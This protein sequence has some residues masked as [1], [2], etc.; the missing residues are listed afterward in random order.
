M[1]MRGLGETHNADGKPDVDARLKTQ[2]SLTRKIKTKSLERNKPTEQSAAK[3]GDALRYTM[4]A[5]TADYGPHTQAVFDRLMAEGYTVHEAD[6]SWVEGNTYKGINASIVAP[7]GTTFEL[8]FHTPESFVLKDGDLHEHYETMR[9]PAKPYDERLAAYKACVALSAKLPDPPGVETVGDLKRYGAPEPPKAENA[10]KPKVLDVASTDFG[11]SHHPADATNPS[12]V[13]GKQWGGWD[14]LPTTDLNLS[15]TPLN[16]TEEMLASSSIN[17]VVKGGEELRA[18]Y[19]PHIVIDGHHRVAMYGGLHRDT[20]PAKIYDERTMG[21][22]GRLTNVPPEVSDALAAIKINGRPDGEGTLE[23]PIAVG[24][25]LDLAVKLLGEGKHIRLNQPEQVA[26]LVGRLAA[27]ATRLRD[28]G[29]DEP[30]FDLCHVSVPGTNLFCSES[31][32]IDRSDMPQFSGQAVPG[33]PAAEIANAKGKADVSAAFRAELKARGISVVAR[34]MPASHLRATQRELNGA[35]IGGMMSALAA[36]DLPP[37]A[38]FVTREGYV[39]DGHH[40]WAANV[41]VDVQDNRLG[42]SE[43]PVEVVDMDVGAAIDFANEFTKRMGIKAKAVNEGFPA[44][45]AA[46]TA[47]AGVPAPALTPT[48]D[49]VVS[50]IATL[51]PDRVAALVGAGGVEAATPEQLRALID[52]AAKAEAKV[53][54]APDAVAAALASLR[55]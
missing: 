46:P 1:K 4:T 54:I 10:K 34:T 20:M 31:K 49:A 33:S 8:Q 23:D 32:G 35:K 48:G 55:R 26:T 41:A 45:A 29:Q 40:R 37:G 47:T 50:A 19:D 13:V 9:D 51:G 27:E 2:E 21:P 3:I 24:D 42:D 18:G 16:A 6:N 30:H 11:M 5:D 22:I 15:E 44:D 52:A 53:I 39:I 14:D 38:I 7:D 28:S 17:K 43:M 12:V 25:D 36:G